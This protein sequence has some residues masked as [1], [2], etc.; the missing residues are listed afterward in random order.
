VAVAQP[1]TIQALGVVTPDDV[2]AAC[3][4]CTWSARLYLFDVN[5]NY[6]TSTAVF[7]LANSSSNQHA[8]TPVA[9]PGNTSY[10]I[11]ASFVP[12]SE[13]QGPEFWR[14]KDSSSSLISTTI[15][16]INATPPALTAPF[17][18]PVDGNFPWAYFLVGA[19]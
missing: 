17:S 18:P 1:I 5:L 16:S 19:Q 4:G 13:G 11:L 8:V 2:D 15:A 3:P 12:P 10:W 7:S 6:V 14:V 9:L